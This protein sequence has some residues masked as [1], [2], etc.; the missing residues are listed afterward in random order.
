M[1]DAPVTPRYEDA[2]GTTFTVEEAMPQ[3]PATSAPI[4]T[5]LHLVERQRVDAAGAGLYRTIHRNSLTEVLR[6]LKER[7]I[8]AV[9]VSAARCDAAERG[10]MAAV[11]REFPRVPAVAILSDVEPTSASAVLALGNCGV[12]TL[13][14]VRS[15][16]G[17]HQLRTLLG[18][19]VT[20]DIDRAMLALL[21]TDLE[22]VADDCWSF[23]EA[24]FSSDART[25]TV[26]QLS[27]RLGVLPST[28][29]SRFFRARLP[30]PKRYLAFA[31]LIRAARLFEN[32]G[33]SVADVANHLDYSSP[34]SFGRH[35]RTLLRTTAGEFRRS[36]DGERMVD[37]FRNE[38]VLPNQDRLR[39]LR[40]LSTRLGRRRAEA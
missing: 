36:Y 24:I 13:V 29:T 8:G 9:V 19:E 32:P 23:F 28:L 11:V 17:W 6:D 21:R 34:Q 39:R 27:A 40:P 22:G 33:L 26:R 5:M 18:A 38:L 4:A 14:D 7:Q 31:R 20:T 2:P 3:A 37:R 30:A 25:A 15:P 35:V 10:R 12:K 16:R 1:G